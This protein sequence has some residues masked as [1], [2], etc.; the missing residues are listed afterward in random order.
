[1]KL[2]A[3][4]PANFRAFGASDWISLDSE[5]IVCAGSNGSGKTSLAEAVEWLLF[6]DTRRRQR[7]DSYSKVEYRGSYANV[8]AT[9]PVEVSARVLLDNGAL[10]TL[11]RR[12]VITPQGI[13]RSQTF[14]DG[15]EEGFHSLD[16]Y[17]NRDHYPVITQHG[18]QDFVHAGPKER[19]DAFCAMV[20]LD[21]LTSFKTILDRARNSFHRSPPQEV[22]EAR[23]ALGSLRGKLARNPDT[24]SLA[25]TWD[26]ELT[27]VDVARDWAVLTKAAQ[28][29]LD[30]GTTDEL[31]LIEGLRKKKT[32][33]SEKLFD[34]GVLQPP[35]DLPRRVRS[36]AA[37]HEDC[38]NTTMALEAAV[39]RLVASGVQISA[40]GL[41]LLWEAGLRLAEDAASCSCPMC[42]QP[43]L[44]PERREA[45]QAQ[46]SRN[47]S[48]LQARA[49][50]TKLIEQLADRLAALCAE[51]AGILPPRLDA[52]DRATL[53]R[54]ASGAGIDVESHF[55][56]WEKIRESYSQA[57]RLHSDCALLLGRLSRV[58]DDREELGKEARAL[59]GGVR[60]TIDA[61]LAVAGEAGI[62]SERSAGLAQL[63]RASLSST[64]DA[65]QVDALIEGLEARRHLETMSIYNQMRE[66]AAAESHAM[67]RFL[68]EKQRA[69]LS[70]LESGIREYY[71][72]MNPNAV[73]RFSD[74]E[75][76][77]GA[78]RL[79]AESF[80]DQMSAAACLSTS[81]LNC[82]GLA[83]QLVR[84]TASRSPFGFVVLDDP[85]QSMDAEHCESL[86]SSVLPRLMDDEGK[87]VIMLTH[88]PR[89][90]DRIVN[91][92]ARRKPLRYTLE[93]AD[94]KWPTARPVA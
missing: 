6:G 29:L 62:G 53:S 46:I 36:I 90:A 77:T 31:L 40:A 86:I 64:E 22:T 76:A 82:L 71:D 41:L 59:R 24:A 91:L 19:R 7:G 15:S 33:V 78:V 34:S 28:R 32:E 52:E 92:N 20:G 56:T 66:S 88:F 73:A 81:Q 9:D 89:L 51:V 61:L 58:I 2:I 79:M 60:R 35:A 14:V 49:D 63:L 47:R 42:G 12:L 68:Q 72:L 55:D 75:P 83:I 67:E 30:T 50:V 18:L 38:S 23:S 94:G 17:G 21:V 11:T 1:M 85:F 13:E 4:R 54:L 74:L 45:L 27:Q 25:R 69:M 39:S 87:Q 5:L 26:D 44:T 84:T 8:H 70:R 80:G 37:L 10:R 16:I 3:I 48:H 65:K 43:T 93:W 57:E